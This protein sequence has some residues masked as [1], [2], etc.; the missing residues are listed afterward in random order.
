M[1]NLTEQVFSTSKHLLQKAAPDHPRGLR[2]NAAIGQA[3]DAFTPSKCTNRLS[4]QCHHKGRPCLVLSLVGMARSLQTGS[5]HRL[6]MLRDQLF[7]SAKMEIAR[8]ASANSSLVK[9][10]AA[11]CNI[12]R[13]KARFHFQSCG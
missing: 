12:E 9:N 3:L 2:R 10:T 6:L 4:T 8:Q 13:E 5:C 1:V 11:K 7:I